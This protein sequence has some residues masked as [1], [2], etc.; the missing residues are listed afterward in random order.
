[1]APYHNHFHLCRCCLCVLSHSHSFCCLIASHNNSNLD[2]NNLTG[3]IPSAIATLTN[4][5]TLWV[6]QT[7]RRV[8]AGDSQKQINT[9]GIEQKSV[10]WNHTDGNFTDAVSPTSVCACAFGCLASTLTLLRSY[11]DN[12]QLTG[13][14][15]PV[16]LYGNL[17]YL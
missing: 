7:L 9:Q 4:L 2:D 10:E 6:L 14:I 17:D 1:M 13:T 15:P 3:S 16:G 11:L 12:N 8:G 5:K